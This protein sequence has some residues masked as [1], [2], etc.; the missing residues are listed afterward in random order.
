[1]S[2][3][4]PV[5]VLYRA[6][7]SVTQLAWIVVFAVFGSTTLP[8]GGELV[9]VAVVVLA[10]VGAAAYHLAYY[11]RFTYE[12]TGDTLDIRSGVLSLRT[13]EIPLERVQNVDI[14]RNVVQ[15]VLGIARVDVETAGGGSTEAS[16]R[17]VGA[18][19]ADRLQTE[20]GRL[21]R[22]QSA[23]DEPDGAEEVDAV[24][25]VYHITPTELALY[26]VT[27]IDLRLL[28]L[29]SL[30]SPVLAPALFGGED[31][32]VALALGAPFLLVGVAAVAAVGS[33]AIAVTRYY[34]FRL[35]RVGDELR[36]ERGLF[37]RYS[38][39]IPLE[40]VQTV[41][42]SE[43]VIAR[44]FGYASLSVQTAGYAPG[45]S[46]QQ[47]AIPIAERD[48]VLAFARSV[49]AFDDVTVE[50][51]PRRARTRYVVRYGLVVAALVAAAYAVVA[52]TD[53]TG[54]WYATAALFALVPVAAHLKWTNLGYQLQD[55]CVV[56]REGFWTR[57]TR[58]VHYDRLQTV[59]DG[60]TVFQRR[61]DLATVVADTAG[62][63]S[64]GGDARLLDIDDE[65][66]GE[67]REELGRRLQAAL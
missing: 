63:G 41:V 33:A 11:R 53:L 62:T 13:R 66:A 35:F 19:E 56:A 58:V 67:I 12:L 18:D 42:L 24:E 46:G 10:V 43:S 2:R 4:H 22:R 20:I 57:Q 32:L 8:G 26:G 7:A 1:M 60:R 59:I 40:K 17:Y 48:R 31:P 51:P 38:G 3:L 16:L 64:F 50:R 29:L 54:P 34:G 36:Y 21:K 52:L 55:D 61:R 14:S 28:G 15:R 39:T 47:S 45:E 30:A 49:R 44:R 25:E 5:S 6:A 65:R 9:A 37:E 27:S 23:A